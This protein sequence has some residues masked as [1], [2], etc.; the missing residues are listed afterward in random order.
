MRNRLTKIALLGALVATSITATDYRSPYLSERGPIR[1]RFEKWSDKWSLDVWGAGHFREAHKAFI[2]HGTKTHPLTALIFNK[3]DFPIVEALPDSA[4]V[5][6][7]QNYNPYIAW[8]GITISPRVTYYE[9]GADLGASWKYPV[10]KNKG[11]IGLRGRIPFKCI[12][13]EREDITDKNANPS[14]SARI[15]KLVPVQTGSAID[16][17]N[18]GEAN[19]YAKIYNLG[20]VNKLLASPAGASTV[21]TGID[22]DLGF[23]KIFGT[24]IAKPWDLDSADAKKLETNIKAQVGI[25]YNETNKEIPAK[26]STDQLWAFNAGNNADLAKANRTDHTI[27]E[28]GTTRGVL[29]N[30]PAFLKGIGF[31]STADTAAVAIDYD[32]TQDQMNT[33]WLTPGY[34]NGELAANAVTISTAIDEAMNAYT[35]NLYEWLWEK[36]GYEMETHQRTGLGDIELDLFY[37]H[38]FSDKWIGEAFF[39]V[40]FPSG[41]GDNYYD[42]PYR[43]QLGNGEHFVLKIGGYIAW[44]PLGWM[45]IKLD[46]KGG[47]ALE[48]TEHRMAAFKGAAIKNMGPR[49]DAD[50]DW[51]YFVGCLDFTLF[52]P[53]DHNLCCDIGY[54]FFYKTEDNIKFKQS[55]ATPWYG[56]KANGDSNAADLSNSLMEKNTESIGHKVRYEASWKTSKYLDLCIG[57]A[58]TFAGKDIPR[59]K[60]IHATGIVKF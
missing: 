14:N 58:Y 7:S 55:Q 5:A 37:N 10:W 23:V 19:V 29:T 54:E 2:S 15:K 31:F 59:E 12:E 40:N 56:D 46:L 44:K 49:A 47:F 57:G 53:K 51:Q 9:Y 45:N 20:F 22:K 35:E 36:G 4:M 41:S 1:Y 38:H 32:G 6:N 33:M 27:I 25:I 13:M 8:N 11:S 3:A 30:D 34:T 50:V 21:A 48:A 52:H 39:G 26:A 16:A 43:A 28:D 60:E 18:T 42:N 24:D 17:G